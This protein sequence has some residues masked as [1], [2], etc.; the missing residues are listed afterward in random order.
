MADG[1]TLKEQEFQ[2]GDSFS[3]DCYPTPPEKDGCFVRWDRTNLTQLHFDTVVTATYEPYVTTLASA[4]TQDGHASLLVE[5]TFSAD[6]KL[7]ASLEPAPASFFETALETWKLRIPEDG[8]KSHTVR[9][10]LPNDG[11]FA[12]YTGGEDAWTKVSSNVIGSDLCFELENSDQFTVISV[13]SAMRW[14]W[15]ALAGGV[16]ILGILFF[17]GIRRRKNRTTKRKHG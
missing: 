15:V 17:I 1:K 16:A 4:S 9:W 3:A 7:Q 12:V 8:Q 5:G 11:K 6:D 2:Y 10:R 13:S 14:V